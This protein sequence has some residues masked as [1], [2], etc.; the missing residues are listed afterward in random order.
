MGYVR[1]TSFGEHTG[2]DTEGALRKLESLGAAAYILDLRGNTGGL[3]SAG[4]L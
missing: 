3:V 4:G 1:L 2:R